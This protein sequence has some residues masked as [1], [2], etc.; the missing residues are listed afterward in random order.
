MKIACWNV[1]GAKKS[2][3]RLEIKA[4]C[5][6]LSK[7]LHRIH[8]Q[9]RNQ[10]IPTQNL[11]QAI[12]ES[13]KGSMQLELSKDMI[14]VESGERDEEYK[15]SSMN[16]KA[17][18]GNSL[19]LMELKWV[20]MIMLEK[21]FEWGTEAR[22]SV[23]QRK[24]GRSWAPLHRC[25]PWLSSTHNESRTLQRRNEPRLAPEVPMPL[26]GPSQP[27]PHLETPAGTNSPNH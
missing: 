12:T 19:G 2:Q 21:P 7:T 18:C 27:P 10:V 13:R 14:Y 15:P 23:G 11:V 8:N 26:Y 6:V 25:S 20:W 22:W 9:A 16:P 17:K 3:L 5:H 4:I 24:E 1:Q